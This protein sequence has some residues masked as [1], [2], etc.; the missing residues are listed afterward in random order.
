MSIFLYLFIGFC[1]IFPTI[2]VFNGLTDLITKNPRLH[3]ILLIS[4]CIFTILLW[5][6]VIGLSIIATIGFFIYVLWT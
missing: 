4:F 1:F 5:P 6:I 2:L 3:N